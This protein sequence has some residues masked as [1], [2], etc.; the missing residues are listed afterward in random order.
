M[1]YFFFLYER[2]R[3]LRKMCLSNLL[4]S[5]K[6]PPVCVIVIPMGKG[7]WYRK[8]KKKQNENIIAVWG[9]ACIYT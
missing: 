7:E 8:Q 2:E 5:I 4:V 3:L 9:K 1:I 6:T